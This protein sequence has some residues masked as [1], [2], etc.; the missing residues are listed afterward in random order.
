[1]SENLKE[2]F[3]EDF[4]TLIKALYAIA[5]SRN[6]V[7]QL[8]MLLPLTEDDIKM[9]FPG[10]I[11]DP[12]YWEI[13]K[14]ALGLKKITQYGTNKEI[15]ECDYS[16]LAKAISS[17]FE[18]AFKALQNTS[19]RSAISTIYGKIISNLE[20]EWIEARLKALLNNTDL[21]D[22]AKQILLLLVDKNEIYIDDIKNYGIDPNEAKY[23]IEILKKLKLIDTVSY[24]ERL[25][26]SLPYHIKDRYRDQ[27]IQILRGD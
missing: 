18:Y 16:S 5:P 11:D 3:E 20:R 17:F 15:I 10:I 25:R 2:R 1:M 6:I 19:T 21:S 12:D 23:C 9:L 22:I 14:T 8:I 13:A 26:I 4:K 27:I 7:S 24:G